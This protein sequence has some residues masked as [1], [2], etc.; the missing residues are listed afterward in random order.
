MNPFSELLRK[1]T[2]HEPLN[3]SEAGKVGQLG[4]DKL[5]LY[6]QAY[7][8]LSQVFPTRTARREARDQWAEI[9]G[10]SPRAVNLVIKPDFQRPQRIKEIQS[11]YVESAKRQ[12]AILK[13]ALSVIGNGEDPDVA[14]QEADCSSRTVYRKAQQ[15]LG[16]SSLSLRDLQ[17]MPLELKQQLAKDIEAKHLPP[18]LED[19]KKREVKASL[20]KEIRKKKT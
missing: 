10:I 16:E 15:V 17:T 8:V 5:H 19:L 12:I 20:D 14:A 1:I 18:L 4:A 2:D 13:A 7:E 3:R 11:H 9:L 6:A